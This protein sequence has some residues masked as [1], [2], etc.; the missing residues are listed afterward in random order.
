M[1]L[2]ASRQVPDNAKLV[3]DWIPTGSTFG[4][5]KCKKL[6][7][8]CVPTSKQ[9]K[10]SRIQP[11]GHAFPGKSTAFIKRQI[12]QL[13]NVYARTIHVLAKQYVA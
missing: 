7:Y 2:V 3:P 11:I 8:N 1:N 6:V 10:H 5:K 13:Q 12:E 9:H 4:A